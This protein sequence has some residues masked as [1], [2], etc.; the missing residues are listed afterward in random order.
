MILEQSVTKCHEIIRES[1]ISYCQ[2][3]TFSPFGNST[4]EE[5][6]I[7]GSAVSLA[8]TDHSAVHAVLL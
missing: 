3:C 2:C 6:I 1:V 8:V 7:T 5:H 4:L